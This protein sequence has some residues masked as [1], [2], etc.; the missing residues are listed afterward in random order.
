MKIELD[1]IGDPNRMQVF[2]NGKVFNIDHGTGDVYPQDKSAP[3]VKIKDMGD[4][5]TLYEHAFYNDVTNTLHNNSNN[6]DSQHD[7]MILFPKKLLHGPVTNNAILN[8]INHQC[9]KDNAKLVVVNEAIKNRIEGKLPEVNIMGDKFYLDVCSE[10]L[11]LVND[12]NHKI[13]LNEFKN[14]DGS[15]YGWYDQSQKKLVTLNL[16]MDF[17]TLRHIHHIFFTQPW[18]NIDPI[19]YAEKD[20]ANGTLKTNNITEYINQVMMEIK[21]IVLHIPIAQSRLAQKAF[22][23]LVQNK[24]PPEKTRKIP[25]R[26]PKGRKR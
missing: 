26:K 2:I 13:L 11:R 23:N 19:G 6:V 18:L 3:P 4:E 16:S 21:P 10:E 14:E 12:N 24:T 5:H 7:L 15:M 9:F 20:I 25:A 1:E 17:Q 22:D 8:N